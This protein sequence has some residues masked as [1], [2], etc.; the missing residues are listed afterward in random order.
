MTMSLILISVFGAKLILIFG[1]TT[2]SG[3]I[4][5]ATIF[6][7]NNILNEYYGRKVA[8]QSL[9]VSLFTLMLF[10]I[11]GELVARTVGLG[12]TEHVNRAI[13]VLFEGLPRIALASMG[14]YLISLSVNIFLYDL[15]YR[16]LKKQGIW[17]R[18]IL[19]S[20]V[21]QFVD[22]LIFFTIAFTGT[23]G[24]SVVIEIMFI[25]F[26]IKVGFAMVGTPIIYVAGR[27]LPQTDSRTLQEKSNGLVK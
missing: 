15:M 10:L 2:N 25:G 5:Y 3:N 9:G 18:N 13:K 16:K 27:L 19:S 26:L 1:F 4:F 22:S 20:G 8:Y 7:V 24:Q 14:A 12:Q 6:L 21:G 23:V 11:L 17:M